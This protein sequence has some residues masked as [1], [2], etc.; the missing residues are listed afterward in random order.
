V[1]AVRIP[2]HEQL[3]LYRTYARQAWLMAQAQGVEDASAVIDLGERRAFGG[4]GL[5]VY[6]D[7]TWWKSE[8]QKVWE[9][10]CERADEVFYWVTVLA[11][12]AGELQRFRV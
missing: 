8:D 7:S 3:R 6:G 9:A 5:D 12:R 11:A 2:K 10:R 4:D 1:G